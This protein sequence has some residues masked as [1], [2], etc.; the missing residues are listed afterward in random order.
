MITDLKMIYDKKED[1][2]CE[3][4]DDMYIVF[5][6]KG[7][8]DFKESF[9]LTESAG[10]IFKLCDGKHKIGD[11]YK[12]LCDTYDGPED[13]ILDDLITCVDELVQNHLIRRIK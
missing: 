5:D 8:I 1:V 3:E 4:V 12:V 13:E 11:M 6:G 10:L 9:V 2:R 7:E